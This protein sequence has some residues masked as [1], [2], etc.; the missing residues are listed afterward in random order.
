MSVEIGHK[1]GSALSGNRSKEQWLRILQKIMREFQ[2]NKTI[3]HFE[4]FFC[5]TSALKV[6]KPCLKVLTST[7]S[8]LVKRPCWQCNSVASVP[9]GKNYS[10]DIVESS[11][12]LKIIIEGQLQKSH[13]HA[14]I[15]VDI[16]TMPTK[17]NRNGV[18][19]IAKRMPHL[20]G[21]W[22]AF[23]DQSLKVW[24]VWQNTQCGKLE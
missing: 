24:T 6:T 19:G 4:G 17:I 18:Y 14:S 2:T 15:S 1:T 10:K 5:W 20:L 13:E 3:T 12:R 21:L 7:N 22:K 8:W 23:L 11:M 16:S 9:S